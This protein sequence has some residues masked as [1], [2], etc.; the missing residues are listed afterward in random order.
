MERIGAK[1][2]RTM[3][4]L[5]IEMKEAIIIHLKQ[6]E[7]R[8]DDKLQGVLGKLGEVKRDLAKQS[9]ENEANQRLLQE[10]N[11][12]NLEPLSKPIENRRTES[13]SSGLEL[14]RL[15][16]LPSLDPVRMGSQI[17]TQMKIELPPTEDERPVVQPEKISKRVSLSGRQSSAKGQP[18]APV[19]AGGPRRSPHHRRVP[20]RR[21]QLESGRAGSKRG[22]QGEKV[23]SEGGPGKDGR[24]SQRPCVSAEP[25][26]DTSDRFPPWF[27]GQEPD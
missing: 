5:M 3:E 21:K 1:S 9:Q 4:R 17:D 23:K 27:R 7:A 2:E 8:M 16:G 18:A 13:L 15:I 10:L 12:R 25:L 20:A 19:Q 14:P 6:F 11:A 24:T 22:G 26:S